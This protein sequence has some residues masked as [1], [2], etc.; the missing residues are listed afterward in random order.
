[1]KNYII[2][3]VCAIF[4]CL[5]G[6]KE[7]SKTDTTQMKEVMAI[8]DEVMP[9]MSEIGSLVAKLK[10]KIDSDQGGVAEKKAMEDLQNAHESMMEWMTTIGDNFDSDEILNEKELTPEKEQLLLREKENIK[11]VKEKINSSITKA[12]TLLEGEN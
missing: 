7:E 11:L 3:L 10:K 12:K 4:S 5:I 6:C 9:K 1:M 2:A 8:H